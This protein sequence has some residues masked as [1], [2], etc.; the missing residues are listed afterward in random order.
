[1]CA[2]RVSAAGWGVGLSKGGQVAETRLVWWGEG[3]RSDE[4]RRSK[5]A[6]DGAKTREREKRRAASREKERESER[7]S[8]RASE[9]A[10]GAGGSASRRVASRHSKL[11]PWERG[12]RLASREEAVSSQLPFHAVAVAD[13]RRPRLL[14]RAPCRRLFLFPLPSPRA[15]SADRLISPVRTQ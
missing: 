12:G 6:R 15:P 8:E 13:A 1:M 9:R 14:L 11:E 3:H 2:Q 7:R 5:S 4:T 10:I